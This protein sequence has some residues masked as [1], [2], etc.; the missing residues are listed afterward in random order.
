M[1]KVEKTLGVLGRKRYK[2]EGS[3]RCAVPPTT[4]STSSNAL[5]CKV[6]AGTNDLDFN[7]EHHAMSAIENLLACGV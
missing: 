1:G 3:C 2:L 4:F 7:Q 5:A 6:A